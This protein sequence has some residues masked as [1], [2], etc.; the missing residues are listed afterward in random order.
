MKGRNSKGPDEGRGDPAHPSA[1][2]LHNPLYKLYP[3]AFADTD[4]WDDLARRLQSLCWEYSRAGQPS[5]VIF[6]LFLY[7]TVIWGTKAVLKEFQ[8]FTPRKVCPPAKGATGS[9]LQ[10]FRGERT[11]RSLSA[12]S[13]SPIRPTHTGGLP[14]PGAT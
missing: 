10:K 2:P 7:L 12:M 13:S 9:P 6:D 8:T 5:K 1:G 11:R 4:F 3:A 14:D